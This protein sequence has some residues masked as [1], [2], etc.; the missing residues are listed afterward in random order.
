MAHNVETMAYAGEV[1]W[2]GL[3]TK[4]PATL[5]PAQM[6]KKAGLE[7]EVRRAPQFAEIELYDAKTGKLVKKKIA[8]G[9]EV[10]YRSTDGRILTHVS[11]DWHE[12]QNHEAAEFFAEFVEA[13]AS[14]EMHT[15][16][17]LRNGELVWFLAKVTDGFTVFGKKDRVESFLLFTNPHQY[18]R[19]YDI[20]FTPIRVVCNNT[21]D[22]ALEGSD[23]LVVKKSHRT[24][25][26]P[27]RVKE[28]LGLAKGRMGEYKSMA[29]FLGTK[30]YTAENIIK[31]YQAVFPSNA[32]GKKTDLS[33][34][35][36]VAFE[37]LDQQ[38]GADIAGGTW[39][40]AFN[41]VTYSIDHLLGHGQ[42][43][44]L[45]SSWYG[46]NRMRKRKALDV[47]MKF[48]EAA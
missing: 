13:D 21:L 30:K 12:I 18:S 41:S 10:L 38:P 2:H 6:L 31:Y 23:E 26:D 34:P 28:I 24:K 22:L 42:E 11:E 15:A 32:E 8:T 29:Q 35:A 36:K 1:P 17:S 5:T 14:M 9:K 46:P 45:V 33:R 25:F 3:G 40:N 27:E 20:R 7:W 39:W 37:A 48:A 19:R 4:V 44:R 16:G 43:T 47:A